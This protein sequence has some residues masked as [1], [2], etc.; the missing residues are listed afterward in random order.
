VVVTADPALEE[1]AKLRKRVNKGAFG[2]A[3]DKVRWS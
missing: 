3:K 2:I 1:E